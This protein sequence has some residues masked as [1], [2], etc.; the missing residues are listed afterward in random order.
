MEA[1]EKLA[2]GIGIAPA[3]E[4][5]GV[6]RSMLYYQKRPK[7]QRKPRPK[8]SRALTEQERQLVLDE[9]HSE[10]FVDK[11]PGQ[12]CGP[13]CWMREGISAL[14]AACTA[15]WQTISKSRSGATN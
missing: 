11:S 9:L 1:T 15:S 12:R 5:L 10:R 3:C 6:A 13:H 14:S 7:G 4:S 2:V 8:P